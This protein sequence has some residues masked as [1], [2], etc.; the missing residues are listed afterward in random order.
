[1]ISESKKE[2]IKELIKQGYKT[3]IIAERLGLTMSQVHY[4]RT[5]PVLSKRKEG[6]FNA[7][8]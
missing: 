3:N 5:R 1:M 2:R 4:I 6:K 7:M 8:P